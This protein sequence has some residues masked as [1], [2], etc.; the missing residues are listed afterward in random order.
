M[1]SALIAFGTFLIVLSF[2]LLPVGPS[3]IEINGRKTGLN[4][5]RK[6][7]AGS[8][9]IK[10]ELPRSN[11][12]SLVVDDCLES[13][14]FNGVPT[15]RSLPYCDWKKPIFLTLPEGVADGVVL[16][17]ARVKNTGGAG[18]FS[19][20]TS[21]FDSFLPLLLF[22]VGFVILTLGVQFHDWIARRSERLTFALILLFGT[23]CRT[24]Y[25]W[26]NRLITGIHDVDAHFEYFD[27]VYA[28]FT[29]PSPTS[30]SECYQP[31]LYYFTMAGLSRLLGGFSEPL[32]SQIVLGFSLL[33]LFISL[34]V[35]FVYLSGWNAI[36]AALIVILVPVNLITE[37]TFNNDALVPLFSTLTFLIGLLYARAP[38]LRKL[39]AGSV[40]VMLGLITKLSF[41]P[42]A[43]W[44]GVILL[45]Y[46]G[47]WRNRLLQASLSGVIIILG[48]S[49]PHFFREKEFAIIGN[50]H[51]LNDNLAVNR[52]L[53]S[54]TNFN[55]LHVVREPFVSPWNNSLHRTSFFEYAFLTAIFGEYQF[56]NKTL[57]QWSI[58][59]IE[60]SLGAA[61]VLFAINV[62]FMLRENT[63]FIVAVALCIL[64]LAANRYL[65]PFA[66]SN[67]YRYI[68]AVTLPIA[69][70]AGSLSQR[71]PH[72]LSILFPW[73]SLIG[74]SLAWVVILQ[75]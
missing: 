64:S 36:I 47:S 7:G 43:A 57:A 10:L 40:V 29:L 1:K 26:F 75:G 14:S 6:L 59:A 55:P 19:P 61:L 52:D 53:H 51:N 38:D 41:L 2:F 73:L 69:I 56:K 37:S 50:V 66:C 21:G 3:N 23:A 12:Y 67:T 25:C 71:S 68:S 4:E 34:Q 74:L 39:V 63:L 20:Q 62:G 45:L 17:E 46:G 49:G 13:L 32:L 70:L 15:N 16:L 30:C 72:F 35:I 11:R 18:Q 65:H 24:F 58:A 42:A 9:L 5:L 60:L 33:T 54:F 48:A 28:S 44:W 31:P 22:G 8:S 27:L